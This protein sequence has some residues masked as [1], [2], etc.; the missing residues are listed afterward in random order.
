MGV[1]INNTHF[2]YYCL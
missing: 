1:I 2:C